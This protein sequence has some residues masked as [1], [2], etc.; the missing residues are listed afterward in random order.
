MLEPSTPSVAIGARHAREGVVRAAV[1]RALAEQRKEIALQLDEAA[2]VMLAEGRSVFAVTCLRDAADMVA[3]RL[4]W[5]NAARG[6]QTPQ[7][8]TKPAKTCGQIT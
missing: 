2:D 5:P 6:S 8:R 4:P 1:A 7:A 3:G